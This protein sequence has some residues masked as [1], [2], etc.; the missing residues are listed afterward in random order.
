LNSGYK[1]LEQSSTTFDYPTRYLEHEQQV[2]LISNSFAHLKLEPV[3]A[4]QF[5]DVANYDIFGNIW[6]PHERILMESFVKVPLDDE[7][8]GDKDFSDVTSWGEL[9]RSWISLMVGLLDIKSDIID[10]SDDKR[11]VAWYSKHF[12]RIYEENHACIDRRV[13][14]QIT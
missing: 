14:P 7:S 4:G 3:R 1:R 8:L 12:G 13:T 11:A 9:L 10:N 2:V 5:A 6:Y